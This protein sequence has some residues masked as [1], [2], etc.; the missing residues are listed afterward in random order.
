MT[1][2]WQIIDHDIKYVRGR[3]GDIAGQP[4]ILLLSADE[5]IDLAQV[6]GSLRDADARARKTGYIT[7]HPIIYQFESDIEM[8]G[9]GN[10]KTAVIHRDG[11]FWYL[12]IAHGVSGQ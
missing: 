2:D 11:D 3:H 7:T 1:K 8:E 6:V 12:E 5:L 9:D 4:G 10:I